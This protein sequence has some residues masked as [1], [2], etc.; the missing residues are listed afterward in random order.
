M[1]VL[2]NP[3]SEHAFQVDA[4]EPNAFPV[5]L[6]R[7]IFDE[8][9]QTALNFI[10]VNKLLAFISAGMSFKGDAPFD[11]GDIAER[12]LVDGSIAYLHNNEE[13]LPDILKMTAKK[14]VAIEFIQ[15]LRPND[16]PEKPRIFDQR[17]K[18][19]ID[20]EGKIWT[21][22]NQKLDGEEWKDVAN[23]SSTTK[24][25]D[26]FTWP[27]RLGILYPPQHLYHRLEEIEE[28][29]RFQTG[30]SA[31]S[32]IVAG[33][34]GDI[35]QAQKEFESDSAVKFVP[36][37][38]TVSRVHA[39]EAVTHLLA[40]MIELLE[41][42]REAT[43]DFVARDNA[44]ESGTARRL[45]MAPMLQ[46]VKVQRK[47]I[48]DIFKPFEVTFEFDKVQVTTVDERQ[49]EFTLL[50]DLKDSDVLTP[51]AFKT[52]ALDLV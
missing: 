22:V 1:G 35:T 13:F 41:K 19:T 51:E 34:V 11:P 8:L 40:N 45:F 9:S 3:L 23:T 28:T 36:G 14:K 32:M 33:Y 10:P 20:K 49:A 46:F 27:N 37:D 16:D 50:K 4:S 29:V 47:M 43:F 26:M 25:E 48:D 2:F 18:W 30:K 17:R 12:L 52:K 44:P 7:E 6:G 21:A 24:A 42:Y 15:A 38:V 39:T 5:Q 31:M